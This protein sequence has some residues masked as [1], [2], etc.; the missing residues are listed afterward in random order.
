MEPKPIEPQTT[1]GV[2]EE[3]KLFYQ[4]LEQAGQLIDVDDH[5]HLADLSGLSSRVTHV[6]RPDGSVERIGFSAY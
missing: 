5:T 4:H 3:S 1:A 2:D 6:R